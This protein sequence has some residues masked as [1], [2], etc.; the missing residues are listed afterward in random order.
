MASPTSLSMI[1]ELLD[2][3]NTIKSDKV[4]E[5]K[6]DDTKNL[7]EDEMEEKLLSQTLNAKSKIYVTNTNNAKQEL[8]AKQNESGITA[9]LRLTNK[10]LT[11]YYPQPI[12]FE[13]SAS[14]K[15]KGSRLA[16][17]MNLKTMQ[18]EIIFKASISN[19]ASYQILVENKADNVNIT[20]NDSSKCILTLS[21]WSAKSLKESLEKLKHD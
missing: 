14:E 15:S 11:I 10:S 18:D 8:L 2:I 21:K 1:N 9:K 17:D 12:I 7:K 3:I 20:C 16:T 13:P 5:C 4:N 19:I 6:E